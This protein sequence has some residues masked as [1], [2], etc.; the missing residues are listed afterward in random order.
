LRRLLILFALLAL[1]V[2]AA[3]GLLYRDLSAFAERPLGLP[4]DG[5][6]VDLPRGQSI[7][8]LA[9][10]LRA[11]GYLDRPALYLEI[12]ARLD[13]SARRI[14][15]GEY[16]LPAGMAPDALLALL[17]SGQ[18]LQY[19]LTIVEGWSVRDLLSNLRN[20][21]I[22]LQTLE[23]LDGAEIMVRLGR[24]DMHPEG[25]FLPDT[26]HFPRGATDLAFLQRAMQAMDSVLAAEWERRAPGLPLETPERAL[27]LASIVEKETSL[28]E[29]R[30]RVAG[31][32]VRRLQIGMRLQ[33]DPT[34]IYGLGEGFDGN[35]RRR[36]LQ[37]DTDYNTY[38]RSGLPPTPIALP[39]RAAIHAS[40]H[41][42]AGD[43]LYFVARGDGSH[44][45]SRTL[46]E[47]NAAVRR[48]QLQQ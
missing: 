4:S 15:A 10:S 22:L 6:V 27:V 38:T 44:H 36:D 5:I 23:G 45:F 28:A 29:E 43:E 26:Y 7:R 40:L 13:G 25:R 8:A 39:G 37:A 9:G 1:L 11:A 30:A 34:V 32:F 14:R 17:V 3:G 31:V 47:H 46:S 35:L 33:T 2:A 48:Y 41:P 18:V 16:R 19:P 21:P 42:A 20:D 24:P 12:L